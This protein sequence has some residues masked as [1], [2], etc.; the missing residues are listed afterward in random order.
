MNLQK[1]KRAARDSKIA[2]S[3]FDALFKGMSLTD[4]A[5][6]VRRMDKPEDMIP[7]ILRGLDLTQA[8]ID[9]SPLKVDEDVIR[10]AV[11][12]VPASDDEVEENVYNALRLPSLK[13]CSTILGKSLL[14]RRKDYLLDIEKKQSHQSTALVFIH[15]IADHLIG[16]AVFIWQ[17]FHESGAEITTVAKDAFELVS[18]TRLQTNLTPDILEN[19]F[20]RDIFLELPKPIHGF[21][22][23]CFVRRGDLVFVYVGRRTK[24]KSL[25]SGKLPGFMLARAVNIKKQ[26]GAIT[27]TSLAETFDDG[28]DFLEDEVARWMDEVNAPESVKSEMHADFHATDGESVR[29]LSELRR[30]IFDAIVFVTKLR[31]MILAEK[32]PVEETRTCIGKGVAGEGMKHRSEIT[33]SVVSLT[34][35]FR[36]ARASYESKGGHIDKTGKK[37]VEKFIA[38]FIR[39]QHYGHNNALV[40]TIFVSPFTNRFWVNAGVHVTKV[41]K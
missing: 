21:L 32:P 31:L 3:V 27:E 37:V 22:E 5:V 30:F 11:E 7:F 6:K 36:D 18:S 16:Q 4:V 20:D 1:I 35:D 29:A 12:S 26:F 17:H 38:G 9:N 8:D 33:V 40:K 24:G 39:R 28:I 10:A 41:V 14:N 23:L 15:E 34:R 2:N 25:E 19:V 13:V